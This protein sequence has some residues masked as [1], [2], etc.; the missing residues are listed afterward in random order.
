MHLSKRALKIEPSPTLAINAKAKELNDKGVNVIS[1]S[2]G[3]P[4]FNTAN[5]IIEAAYQA[6][7]DGQTKY[8]AASG[9]SELKEAI[10][11]K[12]KDD[13]DLNYTVQQIIITNGA[14]HA[15]YNY[16]Q[17]V[18]NPGDEVIIPTPYWVSYPEMVKLADA[19]PIFIKGREENQYKIT[20]DQLEESITE[21]T[22][23]LI[24]NS[25]SNPTGAVYDRAELAA[26][27]DV[28]KKHNILIISDEIYEKLIY[29]DE[30]HVSIASLTDDTYQRTIVVNGLSKPYA[31]T[32]WRIGYAAGDPKII[33]AM[34]DISS[35]STSNPVTFAQYGAI[36]AI[37]GPQDE[38]EKMKNEFESRRDYV[39]SRLVEIPDIKVIKPAGAFYVFIDVTDIIKGKYRNADEFSEKLLEEELVAVVPGSA[40]GAE[41]FI[42]V[43]YATSQEQ[44]EIGL[45]R[46]ESFI[47]RLIETTT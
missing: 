26:L 43:S 44:L 2:A 47:R 29:N 15:L 5:N 31:M 13:N 42:R 38:L 39:M 9:I 8:T 16:F 7:L 1:L 11:N 19:L 27:A 34:S 28:C 41:N 22:K 37:T 40:F 45:N 32:G 36:E 20:P 25:P 23:A 12:L 4:D 21:K 24:I 14:K 30:K 10:V 17:V 18:C 35:H 3:E 6:M 46:I 33:K